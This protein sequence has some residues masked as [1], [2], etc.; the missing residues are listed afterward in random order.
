MLLPKQ[1]NNPN[2]SANTQGEQARNLQYMFDKT[3]DV[4]KLYHEAIKESKDQNVYVSLGKNFVKPADTVLKNV[5]KQESAKAG[6]NVTFDKT[7]GAYHS[8]VYGY[9]YYDGEQLVEV[10]PMI[11][12][13]DENWKA[14]LI[15][16]PQNTN[17]IQINTIQEIITPIPIQLPINYDALNEVVKNSL[18]HIGGA[19]VFVEGRK[20]VHGKVAKIILDYD[21]SVGAGRET[22]DGKMDFKERGYINNVDENETIAHYDEEIIPVDGLDIYG[23]EIKAKFDKNPLYR[24]GKNVRIADDGRRVISASKGIISAANNVISVHN[25]I[26]IDQVDLSTGNIEALGTVIIRQ[27]IAAGFIVKTKGDIIVYGNVEY[28]NL[29]AEGNILI[30]GG[31]IGNKQNR[32]FANGMIY[33]DF[34]RNAEIVCYGDVIVNQSVLNTNIKTNGRLIC[35]KGKGIV[36]GGSISAKK[37]IFIKVAGSNSEVQTEIYAGRDIEVSEKYK[38]ITETINNN[39][40]MI[41]KLKAVL[42]SEY[43]ANPKLF[44]QKLP[45]NRLSLIKETLQAFTNVLKATNALEIE[46]QEVLAILKSLSESVVS[47]SEKI[48]PGV[49]IYI[50]NVRKF[51]EKETFGTEFHFSDKYDRILEHAP[52]IL[53]PKE[54][55]IVIDEKKTDK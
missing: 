8:N 54:Y 41:K 55:D 23:K 1:P 33:A 52:T 44:L 37:G 5:I 34:I 35:L 18:N 31:I 30:S 19:C 53:D 7:T 27:N 22:V 38:V 16:P 39:K 32:I 2:K 25:V 26:E 29:E 47:I 17:T 51:V 13:T 48:F 3:I 42:G 28:A 36:M 9:V 10:Y 15:M 12:I 49:V 46:K 24:L 4:K 14:M 50:E 21:F 40:E 20:P 6:Q 11:Y 43:F 45:N